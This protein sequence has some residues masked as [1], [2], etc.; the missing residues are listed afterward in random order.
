MVPTYDQVHVCKLSYGWRVHFDGSS[1]HELWD[2]DAKRPRIG[3]MADLRGYLAT[4]EWELVDEYGDKTTLE[5]VLEHEKYERDGELWNTRI[6]L[7]DYDDR[8][9]YPWSKGEFS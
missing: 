6:S 3:S 2:D 9:G 8:E 7:D 1:M 4:G 5:E